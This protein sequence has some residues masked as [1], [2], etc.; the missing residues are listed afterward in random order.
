MLEV[1]QVIGDGSLGGGTTAVLSLSQELSERGV[2]V[3]IASQRASHIIAQARERGLR[4]LELEFGTRRQSGRIAQSL[5]NYLRNS[6]PAVV[7]A[8]GA[9]AGLPV[10]MLPRDIGRSRIYTVHGFHYRQKPAG[11]RHVAKMVERFCIRRAMATVF[12][13]N[14]DAQIARQE[15]LIADEGRC[16]V[17][18]NG[19]RE[20]EAAIAP[21]RP[22]FDI[23]FLGRL[24]HQKNPLILPE[25]L[26]ALRPACP[27]LCVIGTGEYETE[28]RRRL[29]EA[30]LTDQV[31]F[32]G[33]R[34]H[35]EALDILSS[36][37]VMLLPSRWEGLPIS[38]V[39]AMHR[40]IPVV[41]SNIPGT[42]ELIVDG[43]TGYLVDI[44]D[45]RGYA[46][47]LRRLLTDERQRREMGQTALRHA[48][49]HFSL[50]PQV[51]AYLS[52]YG[53]VSR[54]EERLH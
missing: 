48:R 30:G 53:R 37:R 27:T 49:E 11:I 32:C 52:L 5:A 36:A 15:G 18:R 29:G 2:A 47:R 10:S 51:R 12:V 3:T 24:H 22:G 31:T 21:G 33:A 26:A 44:E 42:D 4:T 13:S 28:L 25:I 6:P 41:A 20:A 38:V 1:L 8:H 54:R 23:A 16:H 46:D 34:P 43:Q 40:A 39:E 17:I 19:C 45:A 50:E 7:H 14:S 35:A 9:R